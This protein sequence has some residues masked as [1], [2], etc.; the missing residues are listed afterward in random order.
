M[1]ADKVAARYRLGERIFSGRGWSSY[2]ALDTELGIEVELDLV[3]ASREDL[4]VDPERMREVLQAAQKIRGPHVLPLHDWGEEEGFFYLVREKGNGTPL[5]ELISQLGGLPE[6]Q[7]VELVSAAVEVLAEAYGAGLYYLGLNP[8][9]VLV[10]PRGCPRFRRVGYGWILEDMD[11]SQGARVSPY[12][13][14]EVE[15]GKEG[16]RTSDVYSL[17]VMIN[18]ALPEGA[19]TERL[20]IILDKAGHP[21]PARRP[22]SP[23]LLLEELENSLRDHEDKPGLSREEEAKFPGGW[24]EKEG[25]DAET[26]LGERGEERGFSPGPSLPSGGRRSRGW[27][28]KLALMFAGGM[29]LWLLYAALSGLMVGGRREAGG[30]ETPIQ[31]VVEVP[32]LEGLILEEAQGRLEEIGLSWSVREAPSRLWSAGRV[33]A[34]DPGSGSA[35]RPGE[36]VCLVISSGR[37]E[38]GA[39]GDESGASPEMAPPREQGEE[40]SGE[41][42]PA[43]PAGASPA[44][45]EASRNVPHRPRAVASLSALKGP[46]PLYVRMDAAASSDPDGDIV[47]YV[48]NCGDGTVLHGKTV[49][50]VYDPPVIPARFRV[51]LEVFD[52]RGLSD[53]VALTVEVY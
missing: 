53:S 34:Q 39:A 11:P 36:T 40:G 2:L 37:E 19:R 51:M 21:L 1:Y 22:S 18:E 46:A 5:P 13:A 15:T 44:S 3:S 27:G 49:Q 30:E 42:T 23:R 4:P 50:H 43:P 38:E 7:V 24:A 33:V 52:S 25:R 8:G 29:I 10:D 6:A 20:R 35:L 41:V 26:L 32:D 28:R 47:G 31:E 16:T 12:R 14:P 17:A 45:V 9:Q 48:W